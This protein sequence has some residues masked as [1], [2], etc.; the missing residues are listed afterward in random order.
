M[1]PKSIAVSSESL[2][3]GERI[4]LEENTVINNKHLT[5]AC[6]INGSD[7]IVLGHGEAEYSAS[8]LEISA[9]RVCVYE[10]TT[11][12]FKRAEFE[13]GLDLKD[14]INVN[15]DTGFGDARITIGTSTGMYESAAFPWS[16]RN[17]KIFAYSKTSELKNVKMR[18]FCDDYGKAIWL[19]GDS[20]F[21]PVSPARW[22]SYLIKNGYTNHL[23][24]G[25]PGMGAQT[26]IRDFKLALSHAVPKYAV[27]CMGMNNA[28]TTDAINS[29]Y[30]EATAEFLRICG[31][32]DIIPVLSTIPNVPE[33]ING[34]KN[35]WVKAVGCRYVDFSHAVGGDAL[36]SPWYDGMLASDNV[37]PTELGA[38]ALYTQFLIDFPE[39][40]QDK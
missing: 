39:I 38:K 28:D 6:D 30:L 26:A 17:G 1:L 20:Y 15:L 18:W 22:T 7:V 19:F 34:F 2:A 31:E 11:D 13:H 9:T 33:R 35:D 4:T 8:Y 37:H 5:F 40:M 12:D 25:F 16:G 21:N 32:K 14:F 24:S 10:H 27:W 23:M 29:T 3:A 36:R